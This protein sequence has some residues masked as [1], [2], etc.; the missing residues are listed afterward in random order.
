MKSIF[1]SFTIM[2]I[3]LS[4]LCFFSS[5]HKND[6]QKA[7]LE[8]RLTDSPD[9][10]V[11]EVWVDVKEVRIIMQDSDWITLGG[12][13]PGLYN[14]LELTD[15]KDT[16]LADALIPQ[17]KISQIRLVLGENNYIITN[18]GEKKVLST[19]SAQQSGLKVQVHGDVTGGMLYRLIL[20]FDAAK[21]IVKAG[22]S[23]KYNLKPVLRIISFVPSG[24]NIQG[25]VMP[26]TLRTAVYAIN[27]LDTI[28][29]TFTD[30]ANGHY[31]I[32]DVPAGDYKLSFEPTNTNF[33][34]AGSNATVVLGQTTTVDTVFIEK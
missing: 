18:D 25:V 5:C 31:W 7:R 4:S 15:G 9:P 11:K 19:P 26:D 1:F 22:K 32:G 16:L 29:S 14:L 21:S 23:G 3:G 6:S 34:P 13:H 20:D 12:A 30:T 2:T 33:K 28:A 17:G 27:G 8:V 24:G 10:N